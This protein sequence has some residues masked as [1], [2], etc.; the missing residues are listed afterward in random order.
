[1][2]LFSSFYCNTLI[3]LLVYCVKL[4]ICNL[5]TRIKL[6]DYQLQK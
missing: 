5:I 4:Y 1:M 3:Q 6:T 2:V